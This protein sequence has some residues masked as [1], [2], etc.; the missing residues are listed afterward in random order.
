MRGA[1]RAPKLGLEFVSCHGFKCFGHNC[2]APGSGRV[3]KIFAYL[4]IKF[5]YFFA[6]VHIL[7]VMTRE[8]FLRR[9]RR[10]CRKH[11]L[12]LSVEKTRGKGSH[13]TIEVADRRTI[14]KDGELSP[15][16][17]KLVVRQL[18]LPED[19]V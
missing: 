19:A 2:T 16:Y 8:Q 17:I 3:P 18:H 13:M 5:L 1:E 15:V 10:Y 12:A 11:G 4:R 9:L 7:T 14:V 6:K